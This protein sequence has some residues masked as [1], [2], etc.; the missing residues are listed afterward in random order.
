MHSH[1]DFRKVHWHE[2]WRRVTR[3]SRVVISVLF[4]QG[5][6]VVLSLDGESKSL[7]SLLVS[8]DKSLLPAQP[9]SPGDLWGSFSVDGST[10][11][12]MGHLVVSAGLL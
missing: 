6:K 1:S 7:L 3:L 5:N 8:Q 12:D 10:G 2:P 9:C 4:H 11:E